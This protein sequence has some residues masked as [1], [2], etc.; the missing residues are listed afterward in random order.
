[1]SLFNIL[2]SL[3]SVSSSTAK[4][5]EHQSSESSENENYSSSSS[6]SSSD[7]GTVLSK[8]QYLGEE[9][10]E[11]GDYYLIKYIGSGSFGV[12]WKASRK[13]NDD[14]IVALK[15]SRK[16]ELSD[17]E[18][19]MLKAVGDHPYIVKL[20]SA[21]EFDEGRRIVMAMNLMETNL[22]DYRR[23]FSDKIVPDR[24]AKEM[25]RQLLKALVHLEKVN[26]VHTDIKPENI[27][28]DRQSDDSIV[29]QLAD[30]GSAS[31]VNA[32]DLCKYGKTP[33]YRSP[34]ILCNAHRCIRPPADVWSVACVIFELFSGSVLF[35]PFQSNAY[36]A[37]STQSNET[38]KEM[39]KQQL[40]LMVELLGK[41][42]RRFAMDNRD[43][44][45]RH[46]DL[47]D[48]G[49]DIKKIDMRA[50]LVVECDLEEKHAHALF[51]F[52]IPMLMYTPRLRAKP[53]TLLGHEFL[54]DHVNSDNNEE[55]GE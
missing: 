7:D 39:N 19:R 28:V 53:E 12:V 22:F 1:M 36:S 44:F 5:E 52:L 10:E 4:N 40:A 54:A 41:F 26:V 6:S 20:Y 15:I 13:E 35:D 27:L 49:G 51:E 9:D 11:I 33:A 30:F 45:N 38:S 47:K 16:D 21:F 32:N 37:R 3:H 23:A 42:P 31:N 29:L 17:R 55:H 46:G 2:Q 8:D 14:D 48:V 24:E 50:I 18:V 34:E 43:Y 25:T